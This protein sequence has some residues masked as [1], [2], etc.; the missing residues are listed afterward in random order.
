MLGTM[1]SSTCWHLRQRVF[2]K[3]YHIHSSIQFQY[4]ESYTHK[5]LMDIIK[6]VKRQQTKSI[7]N[8]SFT[9]YQPRSLITNVLSILE[10]KPF[11]LR[12][13]RFDLN[14]KI[15]NSNYAEY[16]IYHQPSSSFRK[17]I[18][19]F[20]KPGLYI[21]LIIPSFFLPISRQLEI[22]PTCT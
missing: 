17:T 5:H 20:V 1:S 10:L 15:L 18:A 8:I 4:Q 19:I 7:Y 9:F 11:K 12:C 6:H 21:A 13:L 16:F 3:R 2:E 14:V 22:T